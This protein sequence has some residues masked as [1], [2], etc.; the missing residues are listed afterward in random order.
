MDSNLAFFKKIFFMSVKPELHSHKRNPLSVIYSALIFGSLSCPF[1][2]IVLGSF[3]GFFNKLIF[4]FIFILF[5]STGFLFSIFI[6]E[7]N[8]ERLL[9]HQWGKYFQPIFVT[10]ILLSFFIT[11]S[12][13]GI[14]AGFTLFTYLEY[15]FYLLVFLGI[16]SA[17]ALVLI[18]FTP[19]SRLENFMSFKLSK[20]NQ[21]YIL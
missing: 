2:Y 11:Y 10:F 7:S 16:A 21:F 20:A 18:L 14:V 12:I 4:I 17:V 3:R 5:I 6:L 1:Y 15:K 9:R 19:A 13:L 8:F